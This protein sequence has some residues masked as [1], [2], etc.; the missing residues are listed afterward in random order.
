VAAT[1]ILLP[2]DCAEETLTALSDAE[3]LHDVDEILMEI[4]PHAAEMLWCLLTELSERHIPDA[5]LEQTL[6]F[7][8][9]HDPDCDLDAEASGSRSGMERR[10]ALRRR[11]ADAPALGAPR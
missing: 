1:K 6:R 3:L 8:L 9:E 11:H 5:A 4:E 7:H 10:A 2:H